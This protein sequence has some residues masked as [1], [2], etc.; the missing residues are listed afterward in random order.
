MTITG[1]ALTAAGVRVIRRP[2]GHVILTRAQQN[3]E[4]FRKAV[5]AWLTTPE[6]VAWLALNATTEPQR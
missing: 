6:G 1:P 3:T 2:F 5:Q 4:P